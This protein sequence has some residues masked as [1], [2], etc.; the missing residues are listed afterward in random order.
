[1][2]TVENKGENLSECRAR[3][4]SLGKNQNSINH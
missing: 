2:K 4:D 3:N 1:M